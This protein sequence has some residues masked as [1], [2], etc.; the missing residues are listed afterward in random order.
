MNCWLSGLHSVGQV[1]L[2]LAVVADILVAPHM[3]AFGRKADMIFWEI[4]FRGRY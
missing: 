2:D 1:Y 4:R 3:S